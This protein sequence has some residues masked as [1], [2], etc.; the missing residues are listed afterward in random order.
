MPSNLPI[1]IY[2]FNKNQ[3]TY[4]VIDGMSQLHP[5]CAAESYQTK[6]LLAAIRKECVCVCVRMIKGNRRDINPIKNKKYRLILFSRDELLCVLR[7]VH[8]FIP[9][10]TDSSP[11]I[12][13]F[14]EKYIFFRQQP[15]G[16]FIT[17][18]GVR[19]F[20]LSTPSG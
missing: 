5:A 13:D 7:F 18:L 11:S 17:Y 9:A 8:T 16:A 2:K 3:S 1:S 15:G 6:C 10:A 20:E 4:F 14:K 12:V 19:N